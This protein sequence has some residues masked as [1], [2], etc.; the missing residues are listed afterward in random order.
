MKAAL[1][2][3]VLATLLETVLTGGDDYEILAAVPPDR[4]EA[5]QCEAAANGVAVTEIGSIRAGKDDARVLDQH[6][7]P[8]A[9]VRPSFSHF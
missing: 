2:L 4:M 6:G 5:L 1:T 3:A 9:F 7:N 8:L